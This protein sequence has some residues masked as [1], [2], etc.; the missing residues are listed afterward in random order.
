MGWTAA[1][2]LEAIVLK[3][4][5]SRLTEAQTYFLA[6]LQPGAVT[7]KAPGADREEVI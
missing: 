7:H 4:T 2:D 1:A 6:Q 3:D 5:M